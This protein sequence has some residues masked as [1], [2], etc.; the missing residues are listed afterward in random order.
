[1]EYINQTLVTWMMRKFKR[2]KGRKVGAI[3][4]PQRL[5]TERVDLFVIWQIGRIGTFA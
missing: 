5:A 3:R 2:F 4:F 1:M